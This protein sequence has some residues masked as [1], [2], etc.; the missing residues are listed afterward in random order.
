VLWRLLREIDASVPSACF[1]LF[2]FAGKNFDVISGK[3]ISQSC[4]WAHW[5]I[6]PGRPRGKFIVGAPEI[7]TPRTFS[8]EMD[9]SGKLMKQQC[10]EAQRTKNL[11]S[12][13]TKLI[14]LVED[15]RI[16]H[17]F[18]YSCSQG[19]HQPCTNNRRSADELFEQCQLHPETAQINNT[20][21]KASRYTLAISLTLVACAG[22]IFAMQ[23]SSSIPSHRSY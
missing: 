10:W 20:Q 5:W 17:M 14:D 13:C 12:G 19:L 16:T 21:S 15:Y 7:T 23:T 8:I 2:L 18:L 22:L 4:M 11:K 6:R 3:C 9:L 1:N